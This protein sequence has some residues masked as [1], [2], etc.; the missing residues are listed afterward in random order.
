MDA[1]SIRLTIFEPGTQK[2]SLTS[3]RQAPGVDSACLCCKML[4]TWLQVHAYF[5]EYVSHRAASL[6]WAE[7]RHLNL[8]F[9]RASSAA[10]DV[11]TDALEQA[12]RQEPAAQLHLTA[13]LHKL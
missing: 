13:P 11:N 7:L 1:F 10:R 4:S 5:S 6:P 8:L 3:L 12:C 9:S 2:H